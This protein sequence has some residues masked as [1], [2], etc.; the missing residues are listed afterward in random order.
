M[1]TILDLLVAASRPYIPFTSSINEQEFSFLARKLS[2]G[3]AQRVSD[4]WEIT[5]SEVRDKYDDAS[6]D[7]SAIFS[8]IKRSDA[9]TLASYVAAADKNDLLPDAMSMNDG[10]EA[11]SPEV[12]ND[13]EKLLEDRREQLVSLPLEEL[14]S[15]AYGRRAH[16]YASNRASETTA[17]QTA[18]YI[19]HDTDKNQVFKS[20]EDASELEFNDLVNLLTAADK[21]VTEKISPLASPVASLS[22]NVTP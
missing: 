9:K 19:I 1:S 8:Q 17:R 2:L 12:L 11:D 3:E 10:K 13:L 21:A 6:V 4:L 15:L 16:F 7:T 20:I 18:V 22:E 5:Y 14:K